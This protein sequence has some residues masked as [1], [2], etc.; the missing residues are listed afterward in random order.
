M[1]A[2][3]EKEKYGRAS[4]VSFGPV[5]PVKYADGFGARGL[6]IKSPDDIRPVLKEDKETSI[7]NHWLNA[8]MRY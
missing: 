8:P 5:D 7:W 4:G 6:M 3:Q 2:I 1:V